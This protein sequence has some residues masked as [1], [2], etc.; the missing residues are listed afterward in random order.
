[1]TTDSRPTVAARAHS[2]LEESGEWHRAAEVAEAIGASTD[3]TRQRLN[4]LVSEGS[5]EKRS[6]GAIIG[7]RIDGDDYIVA[8]KA[9]A[10]DIIR[11]FGDLSEE[12]MKEMSLK[13]LRRYIR[14][15][16][17]ERTRPVGSK[18]EYRVLES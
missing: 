4:H 8:E 18:V 5:V 1:M 12:R 11:T 17:A 9:H 6:S 15:N 3:Y 2:Y 7:S 16:I 13:A 10:Y 14:K